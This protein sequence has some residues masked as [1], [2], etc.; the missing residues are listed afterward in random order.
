MYGVTAE[1][2]LLG[3]KQWKMEVACG[4]MAGLFFRGQTEY[5]KCLI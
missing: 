5:E 2:I 3:Y 4:H 1:P